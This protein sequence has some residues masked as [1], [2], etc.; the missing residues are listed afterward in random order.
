[1]SAP[2]NKFLP[3]FKAAFN[4]SITTNN[5]LGGFRGAGL[6][7]FDPEVVISKLNVL[8]R[9]PSPPPVSN[10]PW[11][12][13]TPSNTLEFG[14]QSKLIQERIQRHVDS[15]STLIVDALEKL[16]KGAE[17]MAHSLVLM[18]DQVAELQAANK[19][20]TQ[21]K[22]HKRKCIQREGTL[23]VEEGQRL[24]ALREFRVRTDRKKAKKRVRAEGGEPSQRRCGRCNRTAHNACT[25]KQA[26]EVA[27]E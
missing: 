27:S 3:C 19:A 20:A 2:L 10:S 9:T 13:Q 5:I 26:V 24:T 1:M 11:Q 16:S 22:S 12:S 23:T 4:A 6:A 18:H 21:R 25:C 17:R 15:S 7:P 8:L 14:L